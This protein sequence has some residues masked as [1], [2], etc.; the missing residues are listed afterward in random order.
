MIDKLIFGEVAGFSDRFNDSSGLLEDLA[1][2]TDDNRFLQ[3]FTL[4]GRYDT[5]NASDILF[6]AL[7]IIFER[8]PGQNQ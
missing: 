8:T 2:E 4:T 3:L 1:V 7:N 6:F 5:M